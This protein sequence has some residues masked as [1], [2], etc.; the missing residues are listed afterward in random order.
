M[1][2]WIGKYGLT[3]GPYE[4]QGKGREGG[5]DTILNSCVSEM[6]CTAQGGERVEWSGV[7][8]RLGTRSPNK[9]SDF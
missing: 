5:L 7:E 3:M 2:G 1:D 6:P 9:H 8:T 4:E